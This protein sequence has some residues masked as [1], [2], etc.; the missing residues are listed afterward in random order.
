MVRGGQV[1]DLRPLD[2]S[3]DPCLRPVDRRPVHAR[4]APRLA[5]CAGPPAIRR[6]VSEL[7]VDRR[8][9]G[10][11]ASRRDLARR[12]LRAVR[13]TVRRRHGGVGARPMGG[14]VRT[15]RGALRRVRH[16]A[17]RRGNAVA[18]PNPEPQ[19]GAVDRPSGL[20]QRARRSRARPAPAL[21]RVLLRRAR[22][23]LWWA[24]DGRHRLDAGGDPAVA[25]VLRLCRRALAGADRTGRPRRVVERHRLRPGGEPGA[26]VRRLLQRQP[27][28]RGQRPLRRP[29]SARRPGPRRFRHPRVPV[30]LRPAGE[31]VRGL[32]RPRA[33]LRV[34]RVGDGGRRAR[35]RTS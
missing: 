25:G 9:A 30:E 26:A 33:E 1:G 5:A 11:R 22:L 16:Q 31:D 4:R 29:R 12:R 20:R 7:V 21:R 32:P 8:L 15:R 28:R 3:D 17:P 34:Q 35:R 24:A 19:P 13:R 18:E 27:G 2:A 10:R 6:V 23:D 14:A